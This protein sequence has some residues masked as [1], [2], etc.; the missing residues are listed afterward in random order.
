MNIHKEVTHI[1]E[2]EYDQVA[3]PDRCGL[4]LP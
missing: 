3:V 2:W 4:H 1:I